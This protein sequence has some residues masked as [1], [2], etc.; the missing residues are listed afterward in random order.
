MSRG[1]VRNFIRLKPLD[2]KK[3]HQFVLDV[4][5]I[6]GFKRY[7]YEDRMTEVITI[8]EQHFVT[9]ETIEQFEE[10]LKQLV[11]TYFI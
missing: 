10:R 8:T 2:T 1:A 11:P 9:N 4:D 3:A 6:I 7:G 5:F